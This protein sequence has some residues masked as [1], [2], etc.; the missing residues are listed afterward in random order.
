MTVAPMTL[1]LR[2]F[3]QARGVASADASA[4]VDA[5]LKALL[6]HVA[7]WSRPYVHERDW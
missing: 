4:L 7:L 3:L 2:E 6:L 1:A 5:W